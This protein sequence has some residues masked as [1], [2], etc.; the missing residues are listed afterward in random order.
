MKWDL[1]DGVDHGHD[2]NVCAQVTPVPGGSVNRWKFRIWVDCGPLMEE[3]LM[4]HTTYTT[5]YSAK[6]AVERWVKAVRN[7]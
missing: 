5:P 1:V 2:G 7:G 4:S 6:R 3:D